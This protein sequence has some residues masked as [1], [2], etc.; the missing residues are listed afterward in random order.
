[1]GGRATW[2]ESQPRMLD[3]LVSPLVT[4]AG[5]STTK[6]CPSCGE[7]IPIA[8]MVCRHCR[9]DYTTGAKVQPLH[10]SDKLPIEAT[11]SPLAMASIVVAVGGVL[12]P[13]FGITHL[14]GLGLGVGGLV[15][16][17]ESQGRYDGKGVAIA[18]I[19]VSLVYLTYAA[20]TLL[21]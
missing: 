16:I 6:T 20:I 18:G 19:V 4:S 15:Q 12:L 9:Y 2:S 13:F 1:M 17:R 14:V 5:D 3:P 21:L 7:G 8:V 11:M 10:D